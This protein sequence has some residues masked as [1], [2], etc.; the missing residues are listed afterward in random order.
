M[1]FLTALKLTIN[2][3]LIKILQ[4][5]LNPAENAISGP[6]GL[7]ALYAGGHY[8]SAKNLLLLKCNI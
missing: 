2:N 8:Y 3:Q 4:V 5:I 6:P 7:V 1:T